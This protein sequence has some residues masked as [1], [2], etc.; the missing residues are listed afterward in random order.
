MWTFNKI[1]TYTSEKPARQDFFFR[2]SRIL[3]LTIFGRLCSRWEVLPGAYPRSLQIAKTRMLLTLPQE[4]LNHIVAHLRGEDRALR[5]LSLVDRRLTEECRIYLF[6]SVRIDSPM[7]LHRWCDAISPGK[8]GPSRYVR[9]L[10]MKWSWTSSPRSLHDHMDHLRSFSRLEHLQIRPLHLGEFSG[11]GLMY[12]F[13]HFSTIRSIYT[14]ITGSPRAMHNFLALFPLLETTIIIAPDI[15][16][17]EEDSLEFPNH[18][19]RG[20]LILKMC[21]VDSVDGLLPS[22]T[23]PTMCCRRLGLGTVIVHS[24]TPLERFF[25]ACGGSLESVQF[26][27][28]LI[29]EFRVSFEDIVLITRVSKLLGSSALIPYF[30]H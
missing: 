10:Y 21:R 5:S 17:E 25:K 1:P 8:D 2:P 3:P 20:D 14:Q 29:R 26:I 15:R 7:K 27:N 16:L 13:G 23:R 9:S 28:L 6:S 24:F 4:T 22:L 11:R 12:W 19:Y 18:V 30:P